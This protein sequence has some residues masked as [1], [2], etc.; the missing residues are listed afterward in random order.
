MI[1]NKFENR[2]IFQQ[3]ITKQ[4][5]TKSVPRSQLELAREAFESRTRSQVELARGAF[6]SRTRSQLELA[7]EAFESQTRSC[8]S[9]V[10]IIEERVAF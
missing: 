5:L 9:I 2:Q 3:F 10:Y 7:R 1:L 8:F 6:E 4:V